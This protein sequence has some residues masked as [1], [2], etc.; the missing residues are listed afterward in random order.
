MP[1]QAARL[2]RARRMAKKGDARKMLV[3][4]REACMRDEGA[5]WLWT[6][7]GARLAQHGRFRDAERAFRH[8]LWLRRTSGDAPRA[9]TTQALLDELRGGYVSHFR[10]GEFQV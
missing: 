8:A 4:L 10:T 5:A 2:T 6:L 3:A 1:T 7:Y 9:R